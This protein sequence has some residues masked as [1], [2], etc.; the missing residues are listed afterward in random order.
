MKRAAL[1]ALLLVTALGP[2]AAHAPALGGTGIVGGLLHPISVPA[3]ALILVGLGLVA[4]QQ[5]GGL[6]A[7]VVM[8]ALGLIAGL[9]AIAFAAG[10]SS[11]PFVLAAATMIAGAWTAAAK[12]LPPVVGWPLMSVAGAA[13]GL[14]SPPDVVDLTTANLML[15]GTGVGAVV[16]LAVIVATAASLQ[17]DWQRLGV[18]IAGSWVAAAAMLVLALA[19][20]GGR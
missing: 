8:F 17:R 11:A 5:A 16:V 12:P 7:L 6:L 9:A 15:I 14:D 10:P 3:H 13:L 18:R 1:A 19:L 4:G 20:A 2:A